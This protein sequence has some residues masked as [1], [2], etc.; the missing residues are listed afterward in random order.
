VTGPNA[1]LWQRIRGLRI[2]GVV[3]A[4]LFFAI[5]VAMALTVPVTPDPDRPSP[6][7]VE[8]CDGELPANPYGIVVEGTLRD[9]GSTLVCR[10]GGSLSVAADTNWEGDVVLLLRPAGHGRWRTRRTCVGC[11]RDAFVAQLRGDT[12]RDLHL[13]GTALGLIGL[14]IALTLWVARRPDGLAE[15]AGRAPPRDAKVLVPPSND[16]VVVGER[17]FTARYVGVS[18][19]ALVG[20]AEPPSS[21][22]LS[23]PGAESDYRDLAGG[24]AELVGPAR[25]NGQRLAAGARAPIADG[26][27]IELAG[28]ES[29]EIALPRPGA[30]IRWLSDGDAIRLPVRRGLPLSALWVAAAG[31]LGVGAVALAHWAP[32]DAWPV[33]G[34]IASAPL[35]LAILVASRIPAG[36]SHARLEPIDPRSRITLEE[37]DGAVLVRCDGRPCLHLPRLRFARA[38]R[39]ALDRQVRAELAHLAAASTR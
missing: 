37:V 3:V 22:H 8:R 2:P 4:G 19:G 33:R 6:A 30:L 34:A 35:L 21:G 15:V 26:D 17:S 5:S 31:A 29:F 10:G 23:L 20:Q 11:E 18:N 27:R 39:R 38:R 32:V 36:L 13:A 25:L 14:A 12:R 9:G 1:L 28:L 7:V 24:L 16:R